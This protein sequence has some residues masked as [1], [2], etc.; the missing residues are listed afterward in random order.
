[1]DIVHFAFFED[2]PFIC[3]NGVCEISLAAGVRLATHSSALPG[4]R[5]LANESFLFGIKRKIRLSDAA[6]LVQKSNGY[7]DLQKYRNAEIL[8]SVNTEKRNFSG[9]G[10]DSWIT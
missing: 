10:L 9:T 6:L 5:L 7:H 2:D 1:M 3:S 8:I 4:R